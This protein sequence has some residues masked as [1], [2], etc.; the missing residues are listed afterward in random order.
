M[1]VHVIHYLQPCVY[2]THIATIC[3]P[4]SLQCPLISSPVEV[5]ILCRNGTP[6]PPSPDWHCAI[7]VSACWKRCER[8]EHVREDGVKETESKGREKERMWQGRE[9]EWKWTRE[10]ENECRQQ[11]GG[12]GLRGSEAMRCKGVKEKETTV[13]QK[14]IKMRKCA[15]RNTAGEECVW[16][17]RTTHTEVWD[18]EQQREKWGIPGTIQHLKYRS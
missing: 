5:W 3:S 14:D 11:M 8:G 13:M 6:P 17:A 12:G 2:V 9:Q 7:P 4:Q 10:N 15:K 1:S 18:K 16:C